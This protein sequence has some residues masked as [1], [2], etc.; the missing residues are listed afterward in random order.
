MKKII[1]NN[2]EVEVSPETFKRVEKLAAEKKIPF[3]AAILFL[4]QK[5]I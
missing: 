4:L 5:V 1:I 2:T 3:S